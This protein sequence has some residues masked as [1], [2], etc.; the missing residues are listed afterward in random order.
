MIFQQKQ[1]AKLHVKKNAKCET[2]FNSS[3]LCENGL[4]KIELGFAI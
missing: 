2:G 4:L 1:G 3:D